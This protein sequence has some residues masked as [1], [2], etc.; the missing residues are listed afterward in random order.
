MWLEEDESDEDEE[1][2]AW[3][4]LWLDE[5]H[6]KLIKIHGTKRKQSLVLAATQ[7]KSRG[8]RNGFFSSYPLI[9]SLVALRTDR[10]AGRVWEIVLSTQFRVLCTVFLLLS[11]AFR[12]NFLPFLARTLLSIA[13]VCLTT[14]RILHLVYLSSQSVIWVIHYPSSNIHLQR[15]IW[16]IEMLNVQWD[17]SSPT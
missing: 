15:F 1:A 14:G 5:I 9:N 3:I 7:P 2:D 12:L 4:L 6:W 11:C 17:V 8:Y 16:E 13:S 10:C